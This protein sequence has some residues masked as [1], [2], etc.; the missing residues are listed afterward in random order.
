MHRFLS[1]SDESANLTRRATE[2]PRKRTLCSTLRRPG[3][4]ACGSCNKCGAHSTTDDFGAAIEHL[5]LVRAVSL[6]EDFQNFFQF[7]LNFGKGRS[8]IRFGRRFE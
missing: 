5:C 1:R 2:G 8:L 4:P 3:A 6:I 7:L